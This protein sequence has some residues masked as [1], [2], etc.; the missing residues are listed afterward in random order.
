MWGD[1]PCSYG[2]FE[3]VLLDFDNS[4]C[5]CFGI[6]IKIFKITLMFNGLSTSPWIL[7]QCTNFA[8]K[9]LPIHYY[10]F[11]YLIGVHMCTIVLY[12]WY[13]IMMPSQL[14]L[15]RRGILVELCRTLMVFLVVVVH[16]CYINRNSRFLKGYGY[17]LV[18]SIKT[19]HANRLW[20]LYFNVGCA[21]LIF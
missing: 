6:A 3:R 4:W 14:E 7:F 8:K 19:F 9:I 16:C 17:L 11:N 15:I 10:V 1:L 13:L 20:F 21:F 5:E 18:E 2:Y 12:H